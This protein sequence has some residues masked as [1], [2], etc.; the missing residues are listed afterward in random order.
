MRLVF[1]ALGWVLGLA[2][3]ADHPVLTPLF[4]LG[5]LVSGGAAFWLTRSRSR[6][7]LWWIVLLAFALGGWRAALIPR[8]SPIAA[9]NGTG[10]LTIEGIV[11]AEPDVRDDRVLL[12]VEAETVTRVGQ[13]TPTSGRVLVEAP[14]T[15]LVNYGDRIQATGLLMIPPTIDAFSYADYLARQNVFSLLQNSAVVVISS[16]HGNRLSQ[17]LLHLKDRA[18]QLINASLPE[19]QAALLSGIL[20]GRERG[21]N[22]QLQDAFNAAGA[23]HIIAISG[24]N[25]V[26]ISGVVIALLNRLTMRRWLSGGLAVIVIGIYTLLV[27]GSAGVIRAAVMSSLVVFAALLRR[28][29]Y[30][31]ASL[32]FVVLLMSIADPLIVRDIGFQLSFFATLGLALFIEPLS[33]AADALLAWFLPQGSAAAL[34]RFLSEPLV[35]TLAAMV[36]TLPLSALY[37]NRLSWVALLVNLLIVPVQGYLMIGGALAVIAGF[38]FAPVAQ[39]LLW[40]DMVLLSW[41][42]GVVRSFAALPFAQAEVYTGYGL[43]NSYFVILMGL[44]VVHGIQPSWWRW[45]ARFIRSRAVFSVTFFSAAA[46]GILLVAMFISRPDGLLHVWFLDVGHHNAVLIQSPGGAHILVD[47]GR[48]P[49][50][51]LTALGDR[52]PFYDRE[53]EALVIT[54]PDEFNYSALLEVLERYSVG[55]ALIN[56][57]PNLSPT[58][59]ALRAALRDTPVVTV[60]KG[61]ALSVND[62]LQLEVLYPQQPPTLEQWPDDYSLLLRLSL[63]EIDFLLTGD[64]SA[65]GQRAVLAAGGGQTAAIMQMPQHGTTGA[66]D[67]YFLAVVQPQVVVLQSDRANPRGDPDPD[68]LQLLGDALLFRTDMEGALHFWTDGQELWAS[69][70]KRTASG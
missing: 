36:F 3:A 27:G 41:T 15:A 58:Y 42:I 30:V 35:V 10:G 59:E 17:S 66:L 64:L 38:F 4:W 11:I 40:L 46:I 55:V 9:F 68:V 44:A 8:E 21:I 63:G 62:G 32:A 12:R 34:G 53:I 45:G 51:L 18:H 19:P 57:Q 23:S 60:S 37:F 2:L 69:G 13:T 31:P 24:F 14:R 56:G 67:E 29:T 7:R 20:L 28:K 1:I 70:S 54:Q 43:V 47:G 25:M 26:I 33:K 61:Y 48:F 39:L 16:D 49:S 65:A 5:L 22:P 52:L 50:R 6:Y